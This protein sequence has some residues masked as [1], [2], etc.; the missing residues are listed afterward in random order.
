MVPGR[1]KQVFTTWLAARPQAWRDDVQVVAMDGFT[2]YKSA[3]TEQ[4]PDAVAVMDSFHVVRLAGD[5]KDP[6]DH[7]PCLCLH[8]LQRPHRIGTPASHPPGT[9]PLTSIGASPPRASP[10][11]GRT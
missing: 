4:L 5:A 3:A 10:H 11:R 9:E 7:I 2:G 6:S 8:S 1:S